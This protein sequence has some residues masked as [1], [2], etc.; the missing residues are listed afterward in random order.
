[1]LLGEPRRPALAG[2]SLSLGC[3]KLWSGLLETLSSRAK[4]I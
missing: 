4:E 1:L 3:D 2:A